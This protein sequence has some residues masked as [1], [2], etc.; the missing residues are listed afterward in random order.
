LANGRHALG[1]KKDPA[2]AD[3]LWATGELVG[4]HLEV[5]LIRSRRGTLRVTRQAAS[6]R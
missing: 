3:D 2:D 1:G 5:T 6:F 4:E